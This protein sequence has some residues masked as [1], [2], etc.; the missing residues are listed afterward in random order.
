MM[1]E[2]VIVIGAGPAGIA[3]AIQLRRFGLDPLLLERDRL[4]GLLVNANLVENYPGFP[5]GIR[6]AELVKLF[7]AQLR[8]VGVS[9]SVEEATALDYS[10]GFLIQTPRRRLTARIVVIA[11]GT[12]LQNPL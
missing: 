9:I 8:R 4:G 11:S 12:H 6:G 10:D 5:E 1:T 3:A 7:E 2:D